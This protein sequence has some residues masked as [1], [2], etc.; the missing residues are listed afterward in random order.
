MSG[1][2]APVLRAWL[3]EGAAVA[4]VLIT[5]ARGSTPRD[6][7]AA[8]L[9]TAEG[10]HGTIGGGR[11]EMLATARAREALASGEGPVSLDVPLGPEIGQCCGGRVRLRIERADAAMLVAI[12]AAEREDAARLP[13]VAVFGAG[14]VGRALSRG[15]ALLP[16]RVRLIDARPELYDPAVPATTERI[17]TDDVESEVA[18]LPAGSACVVVTHS[19]ALDAVVVQAAL[20][21]DDLAYVGLIGSAT[22]RRRFE[23]AFREQGVSAARLVC[24]IGGGTG[25]DKRPEVIAALTAAEILVAFSH[26]EQRRKSPAVAA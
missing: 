23:R 10:T 16:V 24:P 2:L 11:L 18:R 3:A 5:E 20:P 6:A 14:H 4:R 1:I 17:A 26:A 21:R 8:M 22:K 9:V 12:A 19:H 13:L 15:L 7:G 25:R